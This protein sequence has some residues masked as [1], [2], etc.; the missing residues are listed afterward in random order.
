[1]E[2]QRL[3]GE[4]LL[5]DTRTARPGVHCSLQH[6]RGRR[7]TVRDRI[8]RYAA[9][10]LRPPRAVTLDCLPLQLSRLLASPD[11]SFALLNEKLPSIAAAD[12]HPAD[13]IERDLDTTASKENTPA[14]NW[15]RQVQLEMA[16]RDGRLS[17]DHHIRG[18]LNNR[19][20]AEHDL[21]PIIKELFVVLARLAGRR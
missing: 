11:L 4:R 2:R 6:R 9:A 7:H 13:V 14:F 20:S 5:Q 3:A 16:Q 21:S 18:R 10:K 12:R 1:V 19:G 8:G 15:R 17:R